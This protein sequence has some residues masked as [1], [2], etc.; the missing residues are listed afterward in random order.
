VVSFALRSQVLYHLISKATELA[1]SKNLM[2]KNQGEL[3]LFLTKIPEILSLM[4]QKKLKKMALPL[5]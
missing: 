1:S 4:D 3:R 5:N 2:L